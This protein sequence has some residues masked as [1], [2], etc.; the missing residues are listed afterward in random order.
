MPLTTPQGQGREFVENAEFPK[1]NVRQ[2]MNLDTSARMIL[3]FLGIVK[4][5]F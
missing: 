2:S 5:T 4:P 1:I 3:S